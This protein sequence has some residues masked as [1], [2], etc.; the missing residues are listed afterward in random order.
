MLFRSNFPN[1]YTGTFTSRDT[2]TDSLFMYIIPNIN[3][4]ENLLDPNN[5]NAKW[6]EIGSLS[7][8]T[9]AQNLIINGI[10]TL[11]G[12]FKWTPKC[13][14]VRDKPYNFTI[15]VRDKTCPSPFYDSTFVTLYVKKKDNIKPIFANKY[16]T[17]PD[18]IKSTQPISKRTRR[19]FVNAGDYFQLA[20][21]SIIK[22]YD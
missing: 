15:V 18:T 3:P 13:S 9:T 1:E 6:G 16:H 10:G 14:A 5:L 22:T 20:G 11:Q 17:N 12:Q 2:P 4:G 21:D 19:Y 7:S 8:G